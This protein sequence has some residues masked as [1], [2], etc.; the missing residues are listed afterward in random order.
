VLIG[1]VW[2]LIV[3]PGGRDRGSPHPNPLPG[4]DRRGEGTGNHRCSRGWCARGRDR[5][6]RGG[7]GAAAVQ[8]G[9]VELGGIGQIVASAGPTLSNRG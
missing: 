4:G 9:H 3:L 1:G 6:G 2:A 8:D 5:F 7:L